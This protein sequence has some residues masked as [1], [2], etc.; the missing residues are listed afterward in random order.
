MKIKE[1]GVETWINENEPSCKYDL[2]AT[3]VGVLSVQD[4]LNIAQHPSDVLKNLLQVNL[5][6]GEVFGTPRLLSNISSL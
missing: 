3:C 5:G 4:L 2:T 6:Y 1:F